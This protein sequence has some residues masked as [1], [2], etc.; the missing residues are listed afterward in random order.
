MKMEK[1]TSYYIF[2]LMFLNFL[3][4]QEQTFA[5]PRVGLQ[6]D[7]TVREVSSEFEDAGAGGEVEL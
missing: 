6:L 7:L 2:L 5:F 4:L 3:W 1:N